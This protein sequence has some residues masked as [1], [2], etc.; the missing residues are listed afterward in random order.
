MAASCRSSVVPRVKAGSSIFVAR[1][2][3]VVVLSASSYRRDL[4]FH[5]HPAFNYPSATPRE[6]LNADMSAM[7]CIYGENIL[8]FFYF[9]SLQICVSGDAVKCKVVLY[10]IPR[11]NGQRDDRM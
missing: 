8:P 5:P 3:F 9:I 2:P 11:Y 1:S 6:N 7:L 10:C 4:S